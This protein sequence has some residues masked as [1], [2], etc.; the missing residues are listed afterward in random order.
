MPELSER[1]E[2]GSSA[3]EGEGTIILAPAVAIAHVLFAGPSTRYTAPE[4]P[5]TL[6]HD[7]RCKLC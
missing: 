7:M 3:V 4:T 5:R 1:D 6:E 2:D